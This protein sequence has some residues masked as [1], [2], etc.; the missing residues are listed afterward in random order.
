MVS[1]NSS[2]HSLLEGGSYGRVVLAPETVPAIINAPGR[3]GA[4]SGWPGCEC[5]QR[6]RTCQLV[7]GGDC[8]GECPAL[9]SEGGTARGLRTSEQ[10]LGSDP[11]VCRQ[12]WRSQ[13]GRGG[14]TA[15]RSGRVAV[16]AQG[17]T[18]RAR[19]DACC[20]ESR[21]DKWSYAGIGVAE[22]SWKLT[23]SCPLRYNV[24]LTLTSE[25]KGGRPANAF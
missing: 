1:R 6:K 18:P 14:P 23:G 25:S 13:E 12:A 21:Q 16:A 24:H 9:P 5:T 8:P 15:L 4:A 3:A 2:T 17:A 7:V 11:T 19:D 20:C 10:R 22:A